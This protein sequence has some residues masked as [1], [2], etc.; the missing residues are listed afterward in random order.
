M[1]WHFSVSDGQEVYVL[2]SKNVFGYDEIAIQKS[3]HD[4]RKGAKTAN[5]L[6]NLCIWCA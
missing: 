2:N 6:H 1:Q 5:D 3:L 4:G